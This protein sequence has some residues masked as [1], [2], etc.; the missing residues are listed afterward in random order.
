MVCALLTSFLLVGVQPVRGEAL[1]TAPR[2][3]EPVRIDGRADEPAWSVAPTSTVFVRNKG[4]GAARFSTTARLIHDDSAI[5]VAIRCE[6]PDPAHAVIADRDGAA[7][8]IWGDDC[9]EVFF[10]PQQ[11]R[12]RYYQII[13]NAAGR[14]IAGHNGIYA[15][16][17]EGRIAVSETDDAW[18]MEMRV[19]FEALKARPRPGDRWGL[20]LYR[21]RR[22]RSEGDSTEQ[23]AWH[24]TR[25]GFRKPHLFGELLFAGRQVPASPPSPDQQTGLRKAILDQAA[26]D[27]AVQGRWTPADVSGDAAAERAERLLAL[28]R[29]IIRLAEPVLVGGADAITDAPIFPWSVPLI[30][31][32]DPVI[33]MAA[34]P[35]EFEPATF[36]L[37]ATRPLEDVTVRTGEL[38]GEDGRKLPPSVVDVRQVLCWYQSGWAHINRDERTL[39]PELLI[40]DGSLIEVDPATRQNKLNFEGL[41]TDSDRLRPF[42]LPAFETRQIWL[43]FRPPATTRPGLYSGHLLV[44]AGE[45]P[46]ATAPIHLTVHPFKLAP[47]VLSYSL[48][49]RLRPSRTPDPVATMK[50]MA[51]EIRNQIEHGINM[52]STYVGGEPL[53][54]DGPSMETLEELTRVYRELGLRDHPLILVTTSVGKQKT[55]EQLEHIR[56]MVRRF[57]AW[58]KPRGYS[59]VYF[60]AIDEAKPEVLRQERLGF[61][62]V[63]DAGGKVFVAC[64]ADYFDAVGDLLDMPVI[65]G[66]PRPDVAAKAKALGHR[67]FS[68]YYPQAGVE[69]PETYRRNYGLQLWVAGYDGGFDYEYQQHR[70]ATAYDEFQS[71]HYRNHTMAYPTPGRPIDTRQWEG[72]REGTDDVRYL[73]T[74]L[75][76]LDHAEQNT[77]HASLARE[78]RKWLDTITADEDLDALRA[79][80]VRRITRLSE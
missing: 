24:P 33:E 37:F 72:W 23:L 11:T 36:T 46:I 8:D 44:L 1:L 42:D 31:D 2:T 52:P 59:D 16:L 7:T 29:R 78:T 69:L 27:L 5:Y 62:A 9:V 68:Y 25:S 70:V 32:L 79:E 51:A 56:Q 40:K 19:P 50:R 49:Y 61:Q 63:H 18:L 10:D 28:S 54:P 76:A 45:A 60:Q 64:G 6:E 75:A 55:P 77:R 3:D 57:V 13:A 66:A 74:L 58:A 71:S 26:R 53:R 67:V 17:E 21:T 65:A 80:M 15:P 4:R 43:T 22:A 39:V 47:S 12:S 38:R 48:Y 20:N 30:D 73:S 41:P 35:D 34:C 14:A